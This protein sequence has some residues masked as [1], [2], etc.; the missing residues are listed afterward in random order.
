MS[1]QEIGGGVS[2][3]DHVP[4]EMVKVLEEKIKV[5]VKESCK[6]VLEG[7]TAFKTTHPVETILQK[8]AVLFATA[9]MMHATLTGSQ[10]AARKNPGAHSTMGLYAGFNLMLQ[11]VNPGIAIII[12]TSMLEDLLYRVYASMLKTMPVEDIVYMSSPQGIAENMAMLR[13]EH[14]D[15]ASK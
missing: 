10:M 9:L 6:M 4:P 2:I 7:E 3:Y 14:N 12:I 15:K 8:D 11:Q 1:S 13:K 5:L